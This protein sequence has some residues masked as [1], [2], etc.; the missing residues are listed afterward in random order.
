MAK[1]PGAVFKP[2]PFGGEV[3]RNRQGRGMLH[4]AVSTAKSLPP[5]GNTTWHFY[6][7]KAAPDGTTDGSG[8]PAYCEQY[9]DTDFRAY[10]GADGNDD[11]LI[12]E[13]AGAAGPKGALS[14]R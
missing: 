5:S 14:A 10:G 8:G 9:V 2:T 13:T 3:R 1:Y 6:V 12:V 4:V 7:A 11:Q